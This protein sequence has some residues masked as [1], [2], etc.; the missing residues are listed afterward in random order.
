MKLS[1]NQKLTS[2]FVL[3]GAAAS[4]AVGVAAAHTSAVSLMETEKNAIASLRDTKAQSLNLYFDRLEAMLA[5]TANSP[6]VGKSILTM[7]TLFES[8]P[9]AVST[10]TEK[11]A[12]GYK[13]IA[14]DIKDKAGGDSLKFPAPE[15]PWTQ[16]LQSHY[17]T[18]VYK[19]EERVGDI[20]AYRVLH[21]SVDPMMSTILEKWSLYDIFFIDLKGNIVYTN[22]K[23]GDFGRNLDSDDLLKTTELAEI[24][25]RAK[26]EKDGIFH[27]A[28]F[29]PYAASKGQPAAFMAIPVFQE[30]KCI[31]VFAIQLA[32]APITN[33]INSRNQDDVSTGE[34]LLLGRD[35]KYRSNDFHFAYGMIDKTLTLEKYKDQSN[36]ITTSEASGKEIVEIFLSDKGEA[37]EKPNPDD[38]VFLLNSP[39]TYGGNAY[40]KFIKC[41]LPKDQVEES[42]RYQSNVGI[43]GLDQSSKLS[44]LIAQPGAFKTGVLEDVSFNHGPAVLNAFRS[45]VRG[46][47]E[48]NWVLNVELPM[49]IVNEA[50]SALKFT[51][52]K[53][54][55]GVIVAASLLGFVLARATSRPILANA[56]AARDFAS[57]NRNA[58]TAVSSNDEVGDLARDMNA[59]FEA[60]VLAEGKAADIAAKANASLD[61]SATAFMTC[62]AKR[63]IDYCNPTVMKLLRDNETLFRNEVPGFDMAK[64]IGSCIDS[65]HKNPDKQAR[66]MQDFGRLPATAFIKVGPKTFRLNLSARKDTA[67]NYVGNT[68]EWLD[69]TAQLAAETRSA[70]LSSAIESS[71]TAVMTCDA[72]RVIDYCNPA[73]MKVLSDNDTLFR[74]EVPNFDLSKIIG[75][76]IDIFHKNPA[77]QARLITD[78]S[79]LPMAAFLNIGPKNFKLNLSAKKDAAGQYIGNTVEWFDITAQLAAETR[80]AGLSSA[81][82]SSGTAV[83]T[84]DANRVI[85][86][87]N[88]AVMKVLRENETLFRKE[89]PNFDLSKIIGS[90]IDIFHKNPS[91]QARLI[92]DMSRLPMIAL[93]NIGPKNFKLNLSAKKDAEGKYIG[94]AVEWFDITSQL[95]SEKKAA[96]LNSVVEAVDT[97]LMICDLDRKIT[98]LNPAC[99]TLM[100]EH[101]N[102]F[103][104][105]FKNF[106]SEKLIGVCIDGFHKN[107]AHQANLLG[108]PRNLPYKTE[109]T[110]GGMEFALI[111]LPLFDAEGKYIGSGVQWIDNNSR[112]RYRNE[113]TGVIDA[114]KNGNLSHR[115]NVAVMDAVYKPMLAGINEVIDAVV[116]PIAEIREKL[117]KVSEGDLT[118]YVTGQYKGDHEMLKNSLNGTLDKLNEILLQVRDASTQMSQGASQVSSTSQMISQ[119]ATE[120]SASLEEI[121]AS[122]NEINSQTKGNA[123]SSGRA[124]HLAQGAKDDAEGGSRNMGRMVQAMS[125]IDE[126]AQKISKII[127]VID[128]IAFQTNLLALNAAVEAA[129]AGVH[130]KG[131]A[132]VAEEVR[133]LAA[134]SANAAKETTELIEGSIKKVNAG[135]NVAQLT[136]ESL[137]KIVDGISK[138]TTLVG[139]IAAASNEQ[140]LGIGQ[141]NQGLVQLDQVTQQNTANAEESAAA[142]V[143]LSEQGAQLQELIGRFTLQAKA[144]GGAGGMSGISPDLMDALRAAMAQQ[145]M[146]MPSHSSSKALA[147]RPPAKPAP[148]SLLGG[149]TPPA[150]KSHNDIIPLD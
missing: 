88:P 59:A 138:V 124:N 75:S 32:D 148:K 24:Y 137:N 34:C 17:L 116:A 49:E 147:S 60:A 33:V 57:G 144:F 87:C 38:K 146:Q 80:S 39:V 123:E 44:K 141:V 71:G 145:G 126:S 43:L 31:G 130:G 19:K 143:E 63:V 29:K 56:A 61:G 113:V 121:S 35:N 85:D 27:Y 23:E 111:A 135:S 20:S 97:N 16:Y 74:K 53:I 40:N 69:I 37:V 92:T 140:A 54:L 128:E 30:A 93:L 67:G 41:G 133:N 131:F 95:A 21:D 125:E 73:V 64:V 100:R 70:G 48:I 12:E 107:P 136:S 105:L 96:S 4:I 1:L 84:C 51:I 119:G 77:H 139:E 118:A 134:R 58:R 89:V 114:A 86:Y 76:C 42:F 101:A 55:I 83:M 150:S 11:L 106:D 14:K 62:D 68:V 127:K 45:F 117:A 115:G 110:A 81:I 65:Y 149:H 72:N 8:P 108:N 142:A 78:M 7:S 3:V 129:R 103:R 26:K 79:H 132:V 52:A 18:D 9:P 10:N 50:A 122:M 15:N 112:A 47:G 94:N 46:N 5:Q 6:I 66:M 22:C 120:Q 90:C 104:E 2:A 25:R 36:L 98:Y 91:H 99:Q 102:K 82:E 109:I 13:N 28:D